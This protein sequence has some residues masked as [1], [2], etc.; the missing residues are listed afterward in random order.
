[1]PLLAIVESFVFEKFD[2][3]YLKVESLLLERKWT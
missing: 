2:R 1:M 3:H